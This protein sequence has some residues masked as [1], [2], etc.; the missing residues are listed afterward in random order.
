MRQLW[1]CV[2]A[3]AHGCKM[4]FNRLRHSPSGLF[5]T[6]A[7]DHT[8]REGLAHTRRS[9]WRTFQK[10]TDSRSSLKKQF[11]SSW[12][13][14][15]THTSAVNENAFVTRWVKQHFGECQAIHPGL[16]ST[17]FIG[18]IDFLVFAGISSDSCRIFR[19]PRRQSFQLITRP[20]VFAGSA[21]HASQRWT[22]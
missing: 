19:Y 8:P 12:K 16:F 22:Q 13:C 2:A 11:N 18:I 14:H 5:Q 10:R 21:C 4:H 17:A 20:T 3:I 9:E 1:N 7:G 6:A 15:P